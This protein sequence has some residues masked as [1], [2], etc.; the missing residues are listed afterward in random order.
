MSPAAIR[1]TSPRSRPIL[2]PP[3]SHQG[4]RR[5]LLR[6]LRCKRPFTCFAPRKH[7]MI[8][9]SGHGA[10]VRTAFEST[11]RGV[12]MQ[13]RAYRLFAAILICAWTEG[14][15]HGS[16]IVTNPFVGI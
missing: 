10:C 13:A 12:E 6:T 2:R 14:L 5:I 9:R 15:L 8:T 16:E 3:A 1:K 7:N 4:R 11:R